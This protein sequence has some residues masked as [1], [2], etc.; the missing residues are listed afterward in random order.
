MQKFLRGFGC[1]GVAL[2]VFVTFAV[3]EFL[4]MMRVHQQARKEVHGM[5]PD[6]FPVLVIADK[7]PQIVWG[8]KLAEFKATHPDYSF[9]VPPEKEAEYRQQIEANV[10][11]LQSPPNFD[12]DSELPWSASFKI[13][14]HANGRQQLLVDATFDD[15]R[16]NVGWY[17]ATEKEI[18]PR[19]HTM[20][21]GPGH[22][23]GTF[24][25]AVL[26]T[27]TLWIAVGIVWRAKTSGNNSLTKLSIV[28][29]NG[30][31]V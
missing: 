23:L 31:D 25:V 24:P 12:W 27:A 6:S 30:T 22:V 14:G 21:F 8:D 26:I 11:A 18:Q 3:T 19:Y 29:S 2:G 5:L 10:R 7:R 9:L 13:E 4:L 16:M 17:E 20:Y 15:D 28:R 1:L